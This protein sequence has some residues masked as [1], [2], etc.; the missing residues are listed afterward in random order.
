MLKKVMETNCKN[1]SDIPE[2]IDKKENSGIFVCT[3]EQLI[4][5]SR[6]CISGSILLIDELH[7]YI[8][9]KVKIKNGQL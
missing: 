2:D 9:G 8:K 1:L 3:H 6:E 7:M 5:K 4:Y